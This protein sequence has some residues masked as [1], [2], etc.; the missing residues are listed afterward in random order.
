MLIIHVWTN[1]VLWAQKNWD[2]HKSTYLRRSEANARLVILY[3]YCIV[4]LFSHVNIHQEGLAPQNANG[5]WRV[6]CGAR[7]KIRFL[8]G[9]SKIN[10]CVLLDDKTKT[11]AH[12]Q[13]WNDRLLPWA[14]C[15]AGIRVGPRQVWNLVACSE[16]V[17]I[18][19]SLELFV[20]H[21]SELDPI[22][23]SYLA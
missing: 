1:S 22:G 11:S 10:T 21:I 16:S 2:I 23:I 19:C 8:K 12:H 14:F 15:P 3:P 18:G 20:G 5:S 17:I 9:N 13:N 4:L 7:F 6:A